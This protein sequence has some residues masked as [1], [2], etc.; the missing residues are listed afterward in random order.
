MFILATT[1]MAHKNLWLDRNHRSNKTV[2]VTFT[3]GLDDPTEDV[4][5][6][7]PVGTEFQTIFVEPAVTRGLRYPTE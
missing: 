4:G 1:L 5:V 7:N 3:D 6:N 2:T